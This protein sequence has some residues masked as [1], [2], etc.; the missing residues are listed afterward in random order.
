VN[1][2]AKLAVRHKAKGV[3]K[4]TGQQVSVRKQDRARLC[5]SADDIDKD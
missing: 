2:G 3:V 5:A 4:E 1:G